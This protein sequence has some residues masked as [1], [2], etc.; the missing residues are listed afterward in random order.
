[1]DI[2]VQIIVILV[3]MQCMFNCRIISTFSLCRLFYYFLPKVY[4]AV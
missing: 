4:Y 1:V 2:H 3:T